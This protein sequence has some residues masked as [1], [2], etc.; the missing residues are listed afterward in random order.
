M[1]VWFA[2]IA[3]LG[4]VNIWNSPG[5]LKA[6]NPLEAVRVA[7]TNPIASVAIIGAVFLALTGGE[8]LY[9]DMGHVGAAA[10][11]RAWFGLVLPALPG[12]E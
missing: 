3:V 11:R 8:A 12:N 5:V 1:L 10:I 7:T 9:A 6:L 4:I 2:T